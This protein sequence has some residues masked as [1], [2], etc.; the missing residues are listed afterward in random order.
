[1]YFV[2]VF[3]VDRLNWGHSLMSTSMKEATLEG[4]IW[5]WLVRTWQNVLEGHGLLLLMTWVHATTLIVIQDSMLLN[6]LS[7]RS[8]L[9]R[10][11][12]REG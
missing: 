12:A 7:L 2:D 1:M 4:F 11:C 5:K 10:D 8:L 9:Q 3:V 6:H